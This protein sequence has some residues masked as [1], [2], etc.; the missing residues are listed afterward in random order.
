MI[1]QIKAEMEQDAVI[2][3]RNGIDTL[4]CQDCFARHYRDELIRRRTG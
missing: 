4:R 3:V 2:D 1:R